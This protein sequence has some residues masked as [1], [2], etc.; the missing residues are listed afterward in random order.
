ML[1]IMKCNIQSFTGVHNSEYSEKLDMD[2]SGS[3]L[4]QKKK[5]SNDFL[6]I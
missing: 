2:K 3:I 5:S 1:I 4:G 6:Q